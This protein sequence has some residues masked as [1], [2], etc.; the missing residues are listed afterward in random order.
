MLRAFEDAPKGLIT[1]AQEARDYGAA[2]HNTGA[3]LLMHRIKQGEHFD[4]ELSI[5]GSDGPITGWRRVRGS[6]GEGWV[7]DPR[8]R[9]RPPRPWDD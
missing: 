7:E 5:E 2:R 9:D 1:V 6:H 4:A 8:G 3:G